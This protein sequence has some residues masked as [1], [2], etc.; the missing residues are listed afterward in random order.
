[1]KA[2]SV[3]SKKSAVKL[4]G[5]KKEVEFKSDADI[6]ARLD[7]LEK[8]EEDHL[9]LEKEQLLEVDRTDVSENLG[10]NLLRD[11]KHKMNSP[12]TIIFTHTDIENGNEDDIVSKNENLDDELL[13]NITKTETHTETTFANP[14]EIYNRYKQNIKIEVSEQSIEEKQVDTVSKTRENKSVSWDPVVIGGEDEVKRKGIDDQKGGTHRTGGHLVQSQTSQMSPFQS[15][16]KVLVCLIKIL[17]C[18][19]N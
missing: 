10:N 5:E 11:S 14:G 1:M 17:I 4:A 6:W 16:A 19:V 12:Q 7:E 18:S 13:R 2:A 8:E 15:D 3:K 9:E